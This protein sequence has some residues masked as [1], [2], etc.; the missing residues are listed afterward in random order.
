MRPIEDWAIPVEAQFTKDEELGIEPV[1][2]LAP[3]AEEWCQIL[4]SVRYES[5]DENAMRSGARLKILANGQTRL[6]PYGF[7]KLNQ[8]GGWLTTKLIIWLIRSSRRALS[9]GKATDR[10]CACSDIPLSRFPQGKPILLFIHG[11]ASN[12]WKAVLAHY[13]QTTPPPSGEALTQAFKDEIYAFEHLTDE[14]EPDRQCVDSG[15]SIGRAPPL[16]HI[17]EGDR[18]PICCVSESFHPNT[19]VSLSEKAA[20]RSRQTNM[21]ANS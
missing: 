11:T 5:Y 4:Y 19:S 9:L 7:T 12:T 3:R 15:S 2:E 1:L 16:V 17:R 13:T 6:K 8:L 18:L 14:S 20:N 21:I 10:T